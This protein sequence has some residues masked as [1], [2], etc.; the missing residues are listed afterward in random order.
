VT[1]AIKMPVGRW[2]FIAVPVTRPPPVKSQPLLI[3]LI[4]KSAVAL[5]G[6]DVPHIEEEKIRKVRDGIEFERRWSLS[7][8]PQLDDFVEKWKLTFHLVFADARTLWEDTDPI[9]QRFPGRLRVP[10]ALYTVAEYVLVTQRLAAAAEYYGDWVL[11]LRLHGSDGRTLF[12]TANPFFDVLRHPA[13]AEPIEISV[14][15]TGSQLAAS[16]ESISAELAVKLYGFFGFKMNEPDA[17]SQ[18]ERFR[19]RRP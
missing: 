13:E 16:W 17:R 12:S 5:R 15:V 2:E 18:V 7:E 1:T 9:G 6:W 14:Q 8:A 11:T 3:E 19:D 4:R 10:D